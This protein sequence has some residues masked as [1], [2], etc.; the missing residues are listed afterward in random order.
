MISTFGSFTIARS[1][2]FAAQSGLNVTG[3]NIA[4]INTKGY[5]RQKLVQSSFHVGGAERYASADLNV[6][7]GV[8]CTDISQL[9]D[10]Y[11][12][13]RYRSQASNVGAMDAKLGGLEDIQAVLDEV[14]DGEEGFGILEA[15]FSDLYDALQQLSDQ[16]GQTENDLLVRS[17]AEALVKQFNSYAAQLEEVYENTTLAYNEDIDAINGI[18]E[19]IQKL[20]STIR[21]NEIHGDNSLELRDERNLL[22]DQLAEYIKIDVSYVEEDIGGGQAIEKLVIKLGNANPDTASD[23][24]STTLIDGIYARRLEKDETDPFKLGVTAL[25]NINGLPMYQIVKHNPVQINEADYSDVAI[26]TTDPNTGIV[27]I[28]TFYKVTKKMPVLNPA[29]D[30]NDLTNGGQYLYTDENGQQHTTNDIR[31]AD[32][33]EKVVYYKQTYVQTPSDAVALEDNDLYGAL[34]S[35]RELLTEEGEFTSPDVV[36]NVDKGAAG[37]RGIPF[38]QKALDLLANQFATTMNKANQGG[39]YNENGNYVDSNGEVLMLSGTYEDENGNTVTLD[40]APISKNGL[41]EEQN[42]YFDAQDITLDDYLKKNGVYRGGNLFSI[43]GDTNDATNPDT[44]EIIT[45]SNISISKDWATGPMIVNSFVRPTGMDIASTDSSNIEHI[46]NLF[47][48]KMA[49]CPDQ[50]DGTAPGEVMFNGSFQEMWVNIG[51]ILGNDMNVTTTML[52]TYYAS[53]VNLDSSRD[54]ISGVDLNDEAMNLMQ[55]SK[56]YNAACRLMTTIDSVLDKLI[57]GTAI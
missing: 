51:T 13:I 5:T 47:S 36:A 29:Y 25:K 43:N 22:I 11:L 46:I 35:V 28:D 50:I 20:N 55:Y 4:N 52:D 2:I 39:V 30:E 33:E 48:K 10:P 9:R 7:N 12:D 37:K 54:G 41:T 32:K 15:K 45:A 17:T 38:Y 27:T 3:N 31:Q 1:G 8:K 53:S 21:K 42:A 19:S 56:S 57:N 14:G 26:T 18:L 40:P 16:T 24:D 6:G 44:G 49:Y 34:Q 23:T